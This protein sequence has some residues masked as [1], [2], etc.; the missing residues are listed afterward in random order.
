MA[1]VLIS[2]EAQAEFKA[3]PKSIKP[4]V[5]AVFARLESWPEVSG[6]KWLK[7]EWVGFGR[8]RVGDWRVVFQ[9]I[10]PNVIIVRIQNRRDVYED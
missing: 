8:I 5:L 4:R 10:A 7:Y 6:V 1:N 9:F 2:P 3:L